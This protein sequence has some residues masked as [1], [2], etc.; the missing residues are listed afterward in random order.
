MKPRRCAALLAAV[1]L[2]A[3]AGGAPAA[4][5]PAAV[6]SN[7]GRLYRE[8]CASCHGLDAKGDGPDA[9]IFAA[10]PRNLREGFL[11]KYRTE[12]LV[13]R[14]RDGRPL[15]LALDLPALRARASEVEELVTHLKRLPSINWRR[16]ETG[17]EIYLDRCVLCHGL[18][19]RPGPTLPP[20][21]RA[22]RDLTDAALQ[23]SVSDKEMI[24]L[25]RHGRKGMP[26]LVPRVG[27]D[28]A[29]ALLTFVHLLSP[30]F[31]LYSRYCASCHGDDGRGSGSLAEAIQRP[32]VVFDRAYFARRDPEQLR[33]SVWHMVAEEK[34]A[35]PHY[36]HVL[37]A[38]QAHAIIEYLKHLP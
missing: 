7:G 10:P 28:E 15:E 27:R 17:Q 4:P 30:G 22:P 6:R 36:R 37:S 24:V 3:G 26:A 18:Y 2:L 13:R 33:S 11:S 12:D 16:A 8:Y 25:V 19:G 32:T 31:E 5:T 38:A 20:G 1:I 35:M 21:V 14:V 34:P 23:Q 29:Q 9:A